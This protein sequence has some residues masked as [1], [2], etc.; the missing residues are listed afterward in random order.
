M[1]PMKQALLITAYHNFFQLKE[2]V[3]YYEQY[4]SCYIH[5][6]KK[7]DMTAEQIKE[8]QKYPNVT[9]IQTYRILWGSYK[10]IQAILDLM[11]LALQ[12]KDLMYVHIISGDDFLIKSPAYFE[13]FFS[14]SEGKNFIERIPCKGNPIL[15][16]RYQYYY[17]MHILDAKIVHPIF[18]EALVGLQKLFGI[19]R[20]I[21]YPYKGLIWSSLSKEAAAFVVKKVKE[22]DYLKQIKYCSV[23]EE[24][25]LQ[26]IFLGSEIEE[27]IVNDNLRYN[28]WNDPKRGNPA[29]LDKSDWED[30]KASNKLFARKVQW[31]KSR[32]LYEKIREFLEGE[33]ELGHILIVED[34]QS[35]NDLIQMNLEM[36]G[37]ICLQV[38]D[39]KEAMK[40]IEKQHF[41]LCLLD[42][43]LPGIDGFHLLD[44]F[45]SAE[46]PVIYLTAKS[47]LTDRVK[48]LNLGEEDYIVKPFETLELL[49]RIDVIL[50]RYGKINKSFVCKDIEVRLLER[51]VV[52]GNQMIELT[53]QEY[54]LLEVLVQ[55]RN[56]ALSREKLL[57]TAWGYDYSGETRTVD[58]HI[59]RL[60]KKL[61]WD[62]VIKTVFKYGYRLEVPRE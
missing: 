13:Q 11:E 20:T 48:G 29:V 28:L 45:K 7:S 24:F 62:D 3:I 42:I 56:L 59:Q 12:E 53:A 25:F 4:F 61:G 26:N 47:S 14:Q 23:P 5:I 32:G 27:T 31:E 19:K 38:F 36:V 30:I 21:Q 58:I 35:I 8:L 52:K 17:F 44:K 39:G 41:D 34:E 22:T 49:A 50:R 16:K 2:Y 54:N 9:V 43:M 51:L 18:I 10:H 60:R 33:M 55:N 46:I 57:E 40:E 15:E 6:D 37:H 1:K